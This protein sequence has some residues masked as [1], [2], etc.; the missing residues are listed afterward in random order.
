MTIES[1]TYISDLNASYPAAGDAKSEGDDHIR[2]IKTG[3]KTTFPNISGAV[4]PT[5]TELNYVDGVTSAI[6]T[7]LDA[8]S[9]IASPTFTGGAGFGEAA[10]SNTRVNILNFGTSTT[11]GANTSA[12][13]L[14]GGGV[15][16]DVSLVFTDGSTWNS[17]IGAADSGELYFSV[18]GSSTF[19][20]KLAIAT[21]GRLYGTALHNTGTVTG[22]TNQYIASGTYT[23]TGSAGTN[24]SAVTPR[25]CQWMRVGNVV[26]VSGA[27]SVDANT[28][29]SAA[30]FTL[31]LPIAADF[32]TAYQLGGTAV[33]PAGARYAVY[34][35]ATNNVANFET[36]AAGSA[37]AQDTWF[38]FTY[39]VV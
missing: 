29:G 2:N 10:P 7:Q 22:T 21:D 35:D 18:T 20:K 33:D 39:V 11:A 27:A 9:P 23:P 31:T 3:I 12:L 34:S 32:T 25:A 14:T 13:R 38:S 28:A 8:K 5:H 16:E 1:V 19:G 15:G 30:T 26:T 24:V 6:Q 36:G 4:T 37:S 17:Y